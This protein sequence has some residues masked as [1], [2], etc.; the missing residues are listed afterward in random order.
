MKGILEEIFLKIVRKRYPIY[1]LKLG[2]MRDSDK[3]IQIK[4]KKLLYFPE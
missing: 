3:Y 4:N 2:K 1:L